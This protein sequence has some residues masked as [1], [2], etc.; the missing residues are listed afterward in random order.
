MNLYFDYAAT[1][2][3]DERVLD[4]MLPY[5][6]EGYANPSS[7]H[8]PGQLAR[9]GVELAREQVADA[10]GVKAKEIVFT[11]GA[12]EADNHALRAMALKH[13][14]GHIITS[15][16]EHAAVLTTCKQL[17][18]RGYDVTFL[19]PDTNGMIQPEAVSAAF[20]DNTVLVALMRVNNETGVITDI[21]EIARRTHEQGALLFCDAVQGFGFE[22]LSVPEL[23]ADLLSLSAH[24]IYGP[25][26]AG[27][28]YIKEG[29][30]LPSL[31]FGGE[32]ERGLRAGTHNT[33]AIVGMGAA[34]ALA[35]TNL[36]ER[37][38]HVRTLRDELEGLLLAVDG[39]QL[40]GCVT[41]RGPKHC[42]V[43]VAGVDGEALLM[44][45]DA[46][47][48]AVS[49]GSACA[50]GSIEPSH[51]LLEMGLTHDEAKASIR[52]SVG[53]G[54]THEDVHVAAQ[55]FAEAVERCRAFV[56]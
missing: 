22:M 9:R 50:A 51:V 12:T 54:L 56:A 32:Q 23:N 7:L 10:L 38:N 29:T 19:P 42:N 48:L 25:K 39:V 41:A 1:T 53:D 33:A 21:P 43:R 55:K 8:R 34:A 36:P 47:G 30:E 16:I 26:G 35:M 37:I 45:L 14:D 13:P 52:F 4:A 20:K 6:R 40:N 3:L 11:S 15:S 49:A 46:L 31:L 17:A 2:P 28:L 18:L 44:N 5:L 24:K 27:I